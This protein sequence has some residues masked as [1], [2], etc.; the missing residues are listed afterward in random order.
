MAD[1]ARFAK[2]TTDDEL[3]PGPDGPRSPVPSLLD[4]LAAD[5]AVEVETEPITI[6]VPK[7]P[8]YAVR[9]STDLDGETFKRWRKRCQDNGDPDGENQLKLATLIL[10][11][12]ALCIVKRGVDAHGRDDEPLTFRDKTIQD[13]LGAYDAP[14]AVR[15]FYGVDGHV[16][17]AAQDVTRAAGYGENL[18]EV[19]DPT[20]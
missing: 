11:N 1:P 13:M 16:M 12:Q 6:P 15:R 17:S 4:E 5:L 3:L 19:E 8:G 18:G 2:P 20:R 7:R 10:A 9:F 14:Q